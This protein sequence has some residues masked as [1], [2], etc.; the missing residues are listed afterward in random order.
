MKKLM[1]FCFAMAVFA[2]VHGAEN[3]V[4][5]PSFE[6]DEMAFKWGRMETP[7]EKVKA[8]DDSRYVSHQDGL[9]VKEGRRAWFFRCENP[10]GRNIMTFTALPVVPGKR[11]VFKAHYY[12]DDT[13]GA[14]MVWGNY[15][16]F[17]RNGRTSGYRNLAHFDTTPVQWNEFCCTFYA[18][19]NSTTVNVELIFGGK[20]SVWVDEVSFSEDV[21]PTP[22]PAIGGILPETENFSAHWLSPVTKAT[23]TGCPVGLDSSDETVHIDAAKN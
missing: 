14:T 18:S 6:S 23:P 1:L 16:E 4:V 17:D 12:L 19:P 15:H 8:K 10:T 11:Y 22:V 21:E 13:D 7:R 2:I 9:H 5:N 20:M 3:F